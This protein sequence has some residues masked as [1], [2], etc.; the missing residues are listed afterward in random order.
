MSTIYNNFTI[1]Q[2]SFT[3]TEGNDLD[4]GVIYTLIIEPNQ[5]YS[6]DVNNFALIA[7]YPAGVDSSSATFTQNGNQINLTIQF[8]AGT[9]MPGNNLDVPLCI[10]G[11]ADAAGFSIGGSVNIN[12]LEA[13]PLPQFVTYSNTGGLNET[14]VVFTQTVAANLNHYF[15]TEPV[16][17]IT[18]GNAANYAITNSKV[19]NIDG[20]LTSITFSV[21]YTYP[22]ADVSGDLLQINATAIPIITSTE[23]VNAY[24]IDQ[25]TIPAN[26]DTRVLS[27]IGDPDAVFTVTLNEI[28]T[29]NSTVLANNATMPAAGT[30]SIPG[31]IFPAATSSADPYTIVISGDVNPNI[32]N[33]GA[34]VLLD[35]T[36][37]SQVTF[38][39]Q[40]TA[41][42]DISVGTNSYEFI[43][44]PNYTYA[45]GETNTL[46]FRFKASSLAGPLS[47]ISTVDA[48]SFSPVIPDPAY[49]A[50]LYSI[51]S[52]IQGIDTAGVFVVDGTI[53][54]QTTQDDSI[55][56]T[57]DLNTIVQAA[58][59][60]A[61]FLYTTVITNATST[62]ATSGGNSIND[63]GS[64][65]TAKGVE[66]STTSNFAT[67]QGSTNDGTGSSNYS[68]A[69]T[70]LTASNTYFVRAYATNAIGTGYGQVIQ[71]STGV[72]PLAN[73]A[74]ASTT[75]SNNACSST[76]LTY[77]FYFEGNTIEP[78]VTVYTDSGLSTIFVGDGGWYR[79]DSANATRAVQIT[80]FGK[81]A[82]NMALCS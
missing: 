54:I 35:F 39:I 32:A 13:T 70:G 63:Y 41:T 20:Q 36:Q 18:T 49:P 53:T 31:I 16:M 75:S 29:G 6:L 76:D 42:G 11:F 56:H 14:E 8:L 66:W 17:G 81:I 1:T 58:A 23:Y 34:N 51:G 40:A 33:S 77:T 79:V 43:A 19:Y 15:F 5:G 50:T 67:I 4:N 68:S 55:V 80:N 9:I 44:V 38:T 82:G 22:N 24:S 52:I 64:A 3:E 45:P 65:I 10:Q 73:P 12:T 60:T 47:I 78:G 48:D 21:S 61:P 7:P 26:G 71:F 59:S 62:T 25:S 2:V 28:G 30:Y 57:L 27:L 69:I 74:G 72:T 46:D 37:L